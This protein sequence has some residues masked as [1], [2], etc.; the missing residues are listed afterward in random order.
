MVMESHNVSAKMIDYAWGPTAQAKAKA[1][2]I[3]NTSGSGAFGWLWTATG[4]PSWKLQMNIN[5]FPLSMK[6]PTEEG[7]SLTTMPRVFRP[8][9][10]AHAKP[11]VRNMHTRQLRAVNPAAWTG[12]EEEGCCESMQSLL[13]PTYFLPVICGALSSGSV[14]DVIMAMEGGA[15][16]YGVMAAA[17]KDQALR[18]LGYQVLELALQHVEE[19]QAKTS[20]V[21][22][23]WTSLGV[24]LKTLRDS[25]TSPLQRIPLPIATFVAESIVVVTRTSHLLFSSVTRYLLSRPFLDHAEVPMLYQLLH[26]GTAQCRAERWC[27]IRMLR[28]C[29]RSEDSLDLAPLRKRHVP[30]LLM[31]THDSVSSD[32]ST[33]RGVIDVL[34]CLASSTTAAVYL[35]EHAGIL[36]WLRLLISSDSVWLLS[37]PHS[38]NPDLES[39][40]G[41]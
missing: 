22:R 39:D 12:E 14:H 13:D 5:N 2:S 26:S 41:S 25:I 31:A 23:D 9:A 15:L 18:R 17:C 21:V 40:S 36:S 24:L 32:T 3:V 27:I 37:A 6:V 10:V 4:A 8:L 29:A 34:H 38:R 7:L 19:V 11:H 1:S 28:S 20:G 35:V 33:R 30:S 16:G